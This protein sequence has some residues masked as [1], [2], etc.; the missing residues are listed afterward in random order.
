MRQ[1]AEDA[2]AYLQRLFALAERMAAQDLVVS[3]V[4]ADWAS[5]G[6]WFMQAEKGHGAL[7]VMWDGRERLL[8]VESAPTARPSGGWVREVERICRDGD[9]GLRIAEEQILLWSKQPS[10]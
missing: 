1:P 10:S 7:R 9:E 4:H 6:S 8:T 3:S 5:F 2:R